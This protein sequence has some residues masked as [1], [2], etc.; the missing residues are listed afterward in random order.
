MTQELTHKIH[1]SDVADPFRTLETE[2][3]PD[4]IGH[5]V[6]EDYLVRERLVQ[7][8]LLE[9]RRTAADEIAEWHGAEDSAAANSSRRFGGLFVRNLL[10]HHPTFR[11]LRN[12]AP[13]LGL[14]RAVFGPQMQ[15]H[16][17]VLRVTTP[18][19]EKRSV[20]KFNP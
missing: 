12:F 17:F 4:A 15:V 5:L 19:L 8:E 11:I 14:A 1:H 16:A 2:V 9:E 7:G 13:T 20:W 10:D 18:G 3:A 6:E